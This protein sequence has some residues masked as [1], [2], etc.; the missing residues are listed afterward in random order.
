M[1]DGTIKIGVD[2]DQ[3]GFGKE[4][5]G[6][7]KQSSKVAG[8]IS[9]AFS[10]AFK[11]FSIAI[12]SAGTALSGLGLAVAKVGKDFEAQM[13]KVE[14]ISGSTAEEMERLEAKAKELGATTQFSATEAGQALEYMALAG[15]K[16]EDMLDSLPGLMDLAAASGED[17]ALVSDI[18]TDGL[19]AFG[20]SAKEAGRFAD[21]L[22]AAS[23]NSNTNV[24]M[25]GESFKYVAPVAGALGFTIEDT[26]TALGLMANAGIKASQSGTALRTILTNLTSDSKP[27][28]G[29]LNELGVVTT[30]TNGELL[31]LNDI[32][33]QLRKSFA[34][35]SEVQQAQYA[36]TLA[37][38]EGM[39]GLLA[40]V[41]ASE[42]DFNKLSGAINNSAGTAEEMAKIMNDNL[43]G[44]IKSLKSALEGIAL[45]IYE[46]LQTPLKEVTQYLT[47]MVQKLQQAF[48]QGGLTGLVNS[49][50]DVLSDM[51]L[52]LAEKAPQILQI[53]IDLISSFLKGIN[54]NAGALGES[55]AKIVS[56][57]ITGFFNLFP[58]FVETGAKLLISFIQGFANNIPMIL[59]KA[60]EM[61]KSLVQIII[62]N[63]PLLFKA[64]VQILNELATAITQN[65]PQLIPIALD[66]IIEF[67]DGLADNFGLIIDAGLNLIMAL[68]QSLIDNLPILIEK[69]PI[70]VENIA[71]VINQNAPKILNAGIQLII[72]LAKGLI[73]AIPTLIQAIPQI[74][75]AFVSVWSAF[76]WLSLGKNAIIALKNGITSMIGSVTTTASNL[77]SNIIGAVKS[78]PNTLKNLGIKSVE[79]FI[80]IFKNA[81]N[82]A[83]TVSKNL[84]NAILQGVKELPKQFLDI[85][86]NLISGLWTGISNMTGTL[87]N[88]IK[89]WAGNITDS[90][91]GFFGIHSP[92]KLFRDEI[93]AMLSEGMALG[94]EDNQDVVVD[95]LTS[96]YDIAKDEIN[97]IDFL[98][99]FN[100][101]MPQLQASV[102]AVNRGMIP[103]ASTRTMNTNNNKTIT[104]NQGDFILRIDNFNAKNKVDIE[105]LLT[106]ASFYQK[107]RDNAIGVVT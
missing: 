51:L 7:E 40:I 10:K 24:A 76:N 97:D 60:I 25:L 42:A 82:T 47:E 69:I 103:T 88:N 37:G 43:A 21:V 86:K 74:I 41:N 92:S 84:G 4:L 89:N 30:T 72:A 54:S 56:T 79:G 29:I 87:I 70:I 15:F 11:G 68:A 61:I 107:Q 31:P 81:I 26:A 38:Q 106:E 13:S 62:T 85:G 8:S 55:V 46:E 71:N 67:T 28:V 63:L 57:L 101:K 32:L 100:K 64:G 39:S 99:A 5:Q 23:S 33:Q 44:A 90:I 17:L 20:L 36:K 104:N 93:G 49:L 65:L 12:A 14:A 98:D 66:A 1:A 52:K 2:I 96:P 34:G 77:T 48:N 95:A 3:K 80:N 58:Q 18:L 19:S 59:P 73:S 16:T 102:S 22:A 78:L 94:I 50:G 27:V 75:S 9:N 53:G 83:I 105:T 6:L 35:L 91:K 45:S